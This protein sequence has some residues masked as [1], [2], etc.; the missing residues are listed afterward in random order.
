M[1][2]AVL[3]A[4]PF[5]LN[6]PDF[7]YAKVRSRNINGWS[8]YSDANIASA[9]VLTEPTTMAQ[10]TRGSLTDENL[11]HVKWTAL[12][13]DELRGSEITSY[14]LQWDKG[15]HGVTWYDLVGSGDPYM[16]LEYFATFGDITPGGDYNFRIKAENEFGLSLTWSPIGTITANSRPDQVSIP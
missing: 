7:V 16:D 13:D 8:N 5:G 6:Y 15:T 3:R 14:Y 2:L 9:K 1:P 4:A 11:I 10:P 12:V